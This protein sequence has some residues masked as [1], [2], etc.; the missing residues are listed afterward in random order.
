MTNEFKRTPTCGE[1][2]VDLRVATEPRRVTDA[3]LSQIIAT[4]DGEI[5]ALTAEVTHL[6]EKLA[7]RDASSVDRNS[8]LNEAWDA[9][10]QKSMGLPEHYVY[11]TSR[12]E[13]YQRPEIRR[14][15][16]GRCCTGG[17]YCLGKASRLIERTLIGCHD[18]LDASMLSELLCS[19]PQSSGRLSAAQG[20]VDDFVTPQQRRALRCAALPKAIAQPTD[21]TKGV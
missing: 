21:T 15:P 7:E 1:N 9:V 20:A 16:A 10:R 5:A 17:A 6:A 3:V 12:H 4:K 13:R 11:K 19:A 2:D 18:W 14:A 8:V